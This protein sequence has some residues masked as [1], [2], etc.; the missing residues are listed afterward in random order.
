MRPPAETGGQFMFS[1]PF[2]LPYSLG[3][4]WGLHAEQWAFVSYCLKY[5]QL[6]LCL[7]R[8]TLRTEVMFSISLTPPIPFDLAGRHPWAMQWRRLWLRAINSNPSCVPNSLCDLRPV[9]SPLWASVVPS[10]TPGTCSRPAPTKAG[11]S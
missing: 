2:L 11:H 10:A 3:P 8:K 7:E 9:P 1:L 5:V 4:S 6:I